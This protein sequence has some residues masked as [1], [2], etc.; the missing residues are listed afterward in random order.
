MY[1]SSTLPSRH[2]DHSEKDLK[3]SHWVLPRAELESVELNYTPR[4]RNNGKYNTVVHMIY[5]DLQ[6]FCHP[7]MD[8]H[9][10]ENT[11]STFHK[12]VAITTRGYR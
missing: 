1:I 5:I 2:V 10:I 3:R 9:K 6:L 12:S 4:L 8:A 11:L 7:H